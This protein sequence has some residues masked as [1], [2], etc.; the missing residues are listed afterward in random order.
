MN[1]A[2]TAVITVIEKIVVGDTYAPTLGP[3]WVMGDVDPEA[4]QGRRQP[5]PARRSRAGHDA[6]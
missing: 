6:A 2:G 5:L 4:C 1:A 3:E